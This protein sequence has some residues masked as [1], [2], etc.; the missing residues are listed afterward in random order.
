MPGPPWE[1][2]CYPKWWLL[3]IWVTSMHQLMDAAVTQSW[4]PR[5]QLH[6]KGSRVLWAC[7]SR[8]WGWT[9]AREDEMSALFLGFSKAWDHCLRRAHVRLKTGDQVAVYML[10]V[11]QCN[12]PSFTFLLPTH[13]TN[14]INL[15]S[16]S[17]NVPAGKIKP[18]TYNQ[19]DTFL[20]STKAMPYCDK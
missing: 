10:Y 2:C 19:G 13:S 18:P 11:G 5:R 17:C 1:A 6:R 12:W 16:L 20:P 8:G 3:C 9:R 4:G 7:V 14:F 15:N